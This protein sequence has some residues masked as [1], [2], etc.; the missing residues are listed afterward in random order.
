M[1]TSQ[2]LGEAE[3]MNLRQ[4]HVITCDRAR[5]IFLAKHEEKGHSPYEERHIRNAIENKVIRANTLSEDDWLDIL[6]YAVIGG[7]IKRGEW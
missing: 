2:S 7:M 6:N 3:V 4:S 5:E 1:G